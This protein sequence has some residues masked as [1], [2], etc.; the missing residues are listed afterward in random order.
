MYA[1]DN[2]G[3]GTRFA[4]IYRLTNLDLGSSI[5]LIT[6]TDEGHPVASISEI[7][8]AAAWAECEAWEMHG[9]YFLGHKG[10]R[11]LLTD[12]AFKGHPLRKD[13]PMTGYL[14]CFYA[15]RY[16]TIEFVKV[17]FMQEYRKFE[18]YN[19]WDE[20]SISFGVGSRGLDEEE[21]ILQEIA[22]IGGTE[23]VETNYGAAPIFDCMSYIVLAAAFFIIV[24]EGEDD[25][26]DS[27][28]K[29]LPLQLKEAPA[30]VND[31]GEEDSSSDSSDSS[32]SVSD[33]A[34]STTSS[35]DVENEYDKEWDT[36]PDNPYR[37]IKRP[38]PDIE[39]EESSISDSESEAK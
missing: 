20:P 31:A 35:T 3:R 28:D 19:G 21:F 15:Y 12:Y 25:A 4:I 14:E 26:A 11:R 5:L 39:E 36:H 34:E 23:G 29:R 38:T 7:Y 2:F 24:E 27:L 8:A 10:L 18:F 9:V 1:V 30:P 16:K 17:E 32:S 33:E 6:F 37:I 13:F 22:L